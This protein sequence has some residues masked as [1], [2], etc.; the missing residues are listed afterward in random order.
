M[1]VL[2]IAGLITILDQVSKQAIRDHFRDIQGSTT[3]VIEG[4]FNLNYVGNTG[5][6]WGIFQNNSA[7]LGLL[8]VVV[9]IVLA[10]F[11]KKILRDDVCHRVAFG[12]MVG[13]IAGNLLD[14]VRVGH[15]V[16]F[17]DFYAGKHHFPSFNVADSAICVGV[18]IY[19]ICEWVYG[20]RLAAT[21]AADAEE[22]GE[23]VSQG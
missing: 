17:L 5:A 22:P 16:D 21:E 3:P 10:I 18:T 15:V 8:S 20:R 23:T 4:F 13:G 7:G 11:R 9:L 12:L 2:L 1:Q 14:R 19:I 6:A